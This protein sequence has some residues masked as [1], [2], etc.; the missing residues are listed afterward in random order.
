MILVII[1][2]L[3]KLGPAIRPLRWIFLFAAL[4][5]LF[6]GGLVVSVKIGGGGD[7]H[8]L[9]AYLILLMLVAGYLYA[10]RAAPDQAP[11]GPAPLNGIAVAAL[12]IAMPIWFVIQLTPVFNHQDQAGAERMVE[13]IRINAEKTASQGGKVLFISQRQLIVL[14][15]INVP[16]VPDYELDYLMEMVMSHNRP[17]LDKFHA[18]LAAQ[19]F[20]LIV[21]YA[22][23]TQYDDA[24][25]P[26]R[27]ES[28]YW[29][30]EVSKP[31]LC[32]YEPAILSNQYGVGFY[33]PRQQPCK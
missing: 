27:E 25:R 16:L 6:L 20:G 13:L 33:V 18:D 12:A 23:T 3:R 26:A 19:R 15:G 5:V 1:L 28:N 22:Q 10:G 7:L 9:D 32:Y 17:Y 2:A 24:T 14:D 8:N 21:L 30:D 11:G 31:L 4:A 29:V